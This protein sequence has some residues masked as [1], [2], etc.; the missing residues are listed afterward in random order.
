[1]NTTGAH[2]CKASR[3]RVAAEFAHTKTLSRSLFTMLWQSVFTQ[4]SHAVDKT[5]VGRLTLKMIDMLPDVSTDNRQ[6][7]ESIYTIKVGLHN[8]VIPIFSNPTI[9]KFQYKLVLAT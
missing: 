7:H 9:L 8:S 2:T 3:P 4:T 6:E 5:F 1:M